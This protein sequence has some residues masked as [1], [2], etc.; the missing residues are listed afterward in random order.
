MSGRWVGQIGVLLALALQGV[1]GA[2][3]GMG[4]VHANTKIAWSCNGAICVTNA[5]GSGGRRLTNDLVIDSYPAWSPDGKKIAFTGNLGRTVVDLMNADGSE[6]R[7]LTPRHG[8]DA[9]PAWSP[10]GRTIALDNNITR[11]IDLM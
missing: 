2:E 10:D 7:R 1:T 9:M 5:D 11:Q 4:R 8:D 3:G 6:R